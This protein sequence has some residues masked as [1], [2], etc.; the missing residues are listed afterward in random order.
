[1]IGKKIKILHIIQM[2]VMK[3]FQASLARRIPH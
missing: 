3:D 2:S 1:M